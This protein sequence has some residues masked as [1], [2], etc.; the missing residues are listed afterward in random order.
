[1]GRKEKS[2]LSNGNKLRPIK[3]LS[4]DLNPDSKTGE[5]GFKNR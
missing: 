1:M 4:P 2:G 3:E 5:L